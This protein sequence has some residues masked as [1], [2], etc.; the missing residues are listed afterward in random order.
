MLG[1]IALRTSF[2]KRLGRLEATLIPKRPRGHHV[3]EITADPK[4]FSNLGEVHAWYGNSCEIWRAG[5]IASGKA[6]EDDDFV[7]VLRVV[8]YPP[9]WDEPDAWE[10]QKTLSENRGSTSGTALSIPGWQSHRAR[11][12]RV[13]SSFEG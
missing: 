5:L 2:E 12:Y 13:S 4:D 3:H 9:D 6:T 1:Q 10:K 8:A 7:Y 11:T